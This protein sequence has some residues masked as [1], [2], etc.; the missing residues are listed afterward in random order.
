MKA[1][2]GLK[3]ICPSTRIWLDNT[4]VNRI[5]FWLT[6]SVPALFFGGCIKDEGIAFQAPGDLQSVNTEYV[7]TF[8]VS[9]ETFRMD[10]LLSSGREFVLA[11]TY[12]DGALGKIS[13]EGYF[14][15]L[16]ESYPQV[17]PDSILDE[18]TRATLILNNSK[19]YGK[20]GTDQF[21][22][23]RLNENLDGDRSH[24]SGETAPQ[25]ESQPYLTTLNASRTQSSIRLDASKLGRE[26]IA[27]WKEKKTLSDDQ[28]FLERWKG[29]ALKSLDSVPQVTRFDLQYSDDAAPAFLQV[30]YRV[31]RGSEIPEEKILRFRTDR[32]TVQ[33]YSMRPDYNGTAWAGIPANAGLPMAQSGQIAAVQEGAGLSVKLR[34]PGLTAWKTAQNRKIK[35][36]KAELEIKPQDPSSLAPPDF[37]RISSREDYQ[38]P[39]ETDLSQNVLNESQVLILLQQGYPSRETAGQA[40]ASRLFAYDAAKNSYRCNITGHIQDWLDGKKSGNSLNLYGSQWTISVNRMLLAPGSVKLRLYYFPF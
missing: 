22:L 15:F 40:L 18:Y 34:F 28:Q 11:G 1:K 9:M 32:S 33:Y 19:P 5:L 26:I 30:Y 24:Y 23:Y 25:Y 4:P 21:G 13:A 8:S 2:I 10:S 27:F 38:N 14:Q 7:D 39:A 36:F 31:K 20:F 37:L 6:L 29:F 17:C 16:P 35:V 3:I 12:Q